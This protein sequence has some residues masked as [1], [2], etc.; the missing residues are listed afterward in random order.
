M[1]VLFS[2]R[3]HYPTG[4]IRWLCED[5]SKASHVTVLSSDVATMAYSQPLVTE[6]DRLM[7]DFIKSYTKQTKNRG[8]AS[9][10][11]CITQ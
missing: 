4:Q 11:F 2:A 8:L 5:H 7:K 9:T 6:S 3:C 10:L 1:I